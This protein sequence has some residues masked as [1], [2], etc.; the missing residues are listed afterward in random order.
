MKIHENQWNWVFEY[1][2]I[3]V[4]ESITIQS[5]PSGNHSNPIQESKPSSL[6]YSSMPRQHQASSIRIFKYSSRSM[7]A[8]FLLGARLGRHRPPQAA[9][10][11]DHEIHEISL[12]YIKIYG[13]LSKSMKSK[14]VRGV[15][16][17]GS[18]VHRIQERSAAEAAA[19]KPDSTVKRKAPT[20]LTLNAEEKYMFIKH[21][22]V[23]KSAL[24]ILFTCFCTSC[25][26]AD[27][28]LIK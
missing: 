21:W 27:I 20:H 3:R 17:I 15:A 5:S 4:F 16:S 23:L 11:Q 26:R 25:K 7:I 1:S 10:T 14:P 9:D 8:I 28:K 18:W 12:N 22:I 2:S 6:E 13:N 24:L 19:C